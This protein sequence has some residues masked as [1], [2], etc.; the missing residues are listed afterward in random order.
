MTRS[1][2]N[3]HTR[4]TGAPVCLAL[5]LLAFSLFSLSGCLGGMQT[6]RQNEPETPAATPMPTEP[7]QPLV[8]LHISTPETTY[9]V[10]EAVPLVLDIRNGKFDLLVPFYSL[11]TKG[12]FTA[13]TV[14]D[15]SGEV[16]APKRAITQEH[17]QKYIQEDGKSV[18]CIQG[19][20][21]KADA[22]E[23]LKL[24]DLQRYY[25]LQPGT[26]TLTLA[27]SLEVYREFLKED[28]PEIV[29]LRRD[30]AR[31]QKDP[32]LQP[33]ARQDAVNYLQEQI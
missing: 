25:Q 13:I 17:P 10:T 22:N 4:T 16:V 1:D 14:K 23:E 21:F 11:A 15:A 33:A 2:L 18:R 20:E 3:R 30:M 29:E 5:F 7:A 32:S 27:I 19:F 8:E 9:A 12:A 26:Y 28:H 31:L 6:N 24:K